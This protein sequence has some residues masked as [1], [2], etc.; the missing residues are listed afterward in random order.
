MMKV[1]NPL[2]PFVLIFI[3]IPLIGLISVFV[4]AITGTL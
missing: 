3:G 2:F 1:D 4:S